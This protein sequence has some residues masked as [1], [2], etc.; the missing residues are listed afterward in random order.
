M[1]TENASARYA[2]LDAWGSIDILHA[3]WEAQLAAVA[4]IG[5]ALHAIAAAAAAA[6]AGL[7]R[8]GRL[9]Y[10]GAGTSARIGVQ[11]GVE[12]PPTF[13]WPEERLGFAIA[14]GDGAILQAVEGAEDSTADAMAW[15]EEAAVRPEDVVIGLSA[16]GTTPFTLSALKAARTL[17]AVTIGV[18]NNPDTPILQHC[19]HP[20]L[21]ATGE[22][23][24]AGSTRMK[25]GTAQKVVLN[26]LSTLVMIRLGRVYR[27]RMIAMRATNKKLRSRGVAMVAQLA[28]C[29]EDAAA[30]ASAEANGDIKLAV[31]IA[32]GSNR[33]EAEGLL[34]R[35]DGSLRRAIAAAD[36]QATALRNKANDA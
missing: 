21:V 32:L 23:V 15:I 30:R 28:E 12:L 3:L 26:L 36:R 2:D 14:G 6:E 17:G 8:D 9:F 13:D 35:H 7:R 11:D 18:A 1:N 4:A 29:D 33:N 24:V 25:A 34:E 31:L 5:P 20:I 16:S 10:V 19:T 22:E 27:G